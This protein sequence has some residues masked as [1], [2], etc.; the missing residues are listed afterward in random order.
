M[1]LRID[2][3]T[4][5]LVDIAGLPYGQFPP[6][7]NMEKYKNARAVQFTMMLCNEKFEEI[8]LTDCIVKVDF[9]IP[10]AHFHGITDEISA[11]KGIP[12]ATIAELLSANLKRVNHVIAHNAAFD[13]A[14]LK[15]ELYRH[16]FTSILEE[17][18]KKEVLCTMKHTAPIVNIRRGRHIKDPRL[19]ELYRFVF[20]EEMKDAH[21]SEFDVRN[22][23]K[24]IKALYDSGR[25]NY[26]KQ[27][28]YCAAE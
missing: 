18:K 25:L 21:N 7:E 14:I 2:F 28:V 8:Q 22:L 27:M 19:G 24:A 16:G 23:H 6:Y 1:S 3:E 5:G 4:T 9:P 26:A 10:N 15:S 20:N 17:L 12:F 11:R 13:L